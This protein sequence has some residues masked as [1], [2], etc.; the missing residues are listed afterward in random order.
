MNTDETAKEAFKQIKLYVKL[1]YTTEVAPLQGFVH[2][3]DPRCLIHVKPWCI[4]V[5]LGAQ[6]EIGPLCRAFQHWMDLKHWWSL[7]LTHVDALCVHPL[8]KIQSKWTCA[9]YTSNGEIRQFSLNPDI[10]HFWL[11]LTFKNVLLILN[12]PAIRLSDE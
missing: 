10:V 3:K 11:K 5:S 9:K 7:Q 12:T 2:W 8:R 4:S 6:E 1:T